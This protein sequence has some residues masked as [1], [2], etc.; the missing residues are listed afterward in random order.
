MKLLRIA[1]LLFAALPLFAQT[2]GSITGHV[3]D[4][5]GAALPGVTVEAR[6]A[7]VQGTRTTVSDYTGLYRMP[8]LPRR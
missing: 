3:T 2:T 8:L 7:A 1:A 5:T 4:S 6:G